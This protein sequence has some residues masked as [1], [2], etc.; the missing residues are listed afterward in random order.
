MYLGTIRDME[1]LRKVERNG[2]GDNADKVYKSVGVMPYLP[3]DNDPMQTFDV[4]SSVDLDGIERRGRYDLEIAVTEFQPKNA[5]K[6]IK[7][8]RV[9]TFTPVK[10][11]K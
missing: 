1:V 11:A 8:I 2:K 9:I 6:P 4:D 5:W 3:D 7:N 10:G